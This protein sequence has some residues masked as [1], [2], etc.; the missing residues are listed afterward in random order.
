MDFGICVQSHINDIAYVVNAEQLGFTHAW[1]ADSQML[2]SDCF[3]SPIPV[4]VSGF[5]PKS[6]HLAGK[7]GD[8]AVL[9]LPSD[10]GV[11]AAVW[12]W[13][14]AG[15]SAGGRPF[16]REQFY[17]TV[18][19]TI[20]V[21]EEGE[22][23]SS[24]RVKEQCGAMAIAAVHFAYDQWRN[25]GRSPPAHMHAIWEDYTALLETY[26]EERRHQRIH[27][28][29]NCWVIPEEEQFL[30]EELIRATCMV[31]TQAQLKAQISA[32]EAAGLNQIMLLPNFDTKGDVLAEVAQNLIT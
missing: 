6:L 23:I 1:M 13:L 24:N 22:S 31:G 10:P 15:A 19:T 5:G 20:V 28:G 14:E 9:G 2:W 18:L 7:Y 3:A 29:H 8:G 11:L 12:Q 27:A 17:T 21:L 32:Y 4:H 26:P 25:F 30:S 16:D